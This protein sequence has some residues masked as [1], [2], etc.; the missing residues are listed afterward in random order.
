MTEPETENL[1]KEECMINAAEDTIADLLYRTEVLEKQIN[2]PNLSEE[3]RLQAEEDL[4]YIKKVLQKN[5]EIL[6]RMRKADRKPML[7][8]SV[9][10]FL[11]FLGYSLYV[12]FY[13]N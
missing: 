9:L 3:E 12:L 10:V 13:G 8:I 5:Q 2:S 1:P 6:R 4:K 11:C 7:L